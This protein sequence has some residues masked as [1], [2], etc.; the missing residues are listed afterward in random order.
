M[1][2]LVDM[3]HNDVTADRA[4]LSALSETNWQK[5]NIIFADTKG[6]PDVEIGDPCV[7]P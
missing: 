3:E 5:R 7:N 4:L 1:L 6:D 2:R